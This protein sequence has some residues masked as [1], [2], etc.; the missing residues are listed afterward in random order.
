MTPRPKK[1]P[2]VLG[3]LQRGDIQ[4]VRKN[5]K[6]NTGSVDISQGDRSRQ[7]FLWKIKS[8]YIYNYIYIYF[9]WWWPSFCQRGLRYTD[10]SPTT[11]QVQMLNECPWLDLA[12]QKCTIHSINAFQLYMYIYNLYCM[13]LWVLLKYL[14]V[15]FF[16]DKA[17]IYLHIFFIGCEYYCTHMCSC[18]NIAKYFR[19]LN[20][21]LHQRY[22]SS[23]LIILYSFAPFMIGLFPVSARPTRH[24]LFTSG[25]C[26]KGHVKT[27]ATLPRPV[28]SFQRNLLGKDWAWIQLW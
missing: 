7:G 22:D 12:R 9:F 11:L 27:D 13:H 10:K 3:F 19:S 6:K 18:A 28:F 20:C 23:F 1:M 15:A 25:L 8:T 14:H 24:Q 5:E 21:F 2:C 26:F 4:Q 17:Y 16:K